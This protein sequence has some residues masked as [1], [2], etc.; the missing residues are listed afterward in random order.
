MFSQNADHSRRYKLR[1]YLC[2]KTLC[3]NLGLEEKKALLFRMEVDP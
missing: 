2:I 3:G 1:R